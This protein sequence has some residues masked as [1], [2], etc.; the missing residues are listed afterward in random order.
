MLQTKPPPVD[1]S[2]VLRS[3][4]RRTIRS[5]RPRET[6]SR[7]IWDSRF[8][9][10]DRRSDS[11]QQRDRSSLAIHRSP[12]F[13]VCTFPSSLAFP[14]SPFLS[15]LV[16]RFASSVQ[17]PDT[18][19]ADKQI[20]QEI[21]SSKVKRVEGKSKWSGPSKPQA[22]NVRMISRFDYQPD[23]CKDYKETGRCGY[24]DSCKV[25]GEDH[26]SAA[27]CFTFGTVAPSVAIVLDRTSYGTPS[28]TAAG[29]SGAAHQTDES[30]HSRAGGRPAIC[31][32]PESERQRQRR[33]EGRQ[34]TTHTTSLW[35]ANE[36]VDSTSD[37][38]HDCT[39]TTPLHGLILL[40]VLVFVVCVLLVHA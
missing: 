14:H 25:S 33:A 39:R 27:I 24:G 35:K 4:R 18:R 10:R 8:S 21:D 13:A 23:V 19:T 1:R 12:A 32:W 5:C 7:R 30:S 26:H 36:S 16:L 11:E 2:I 31:A 17:V 15:L 6:N 29:T 22:S 40:S 3:E 38:A 34:Q 28:T 37:A 9:H 20:T